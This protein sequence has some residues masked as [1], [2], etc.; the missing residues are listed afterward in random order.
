MNWLAMSYISYSSEAT[1]LQII[2]G[3][4]SGEIV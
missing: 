4:Q 2:C 1:C 3:G